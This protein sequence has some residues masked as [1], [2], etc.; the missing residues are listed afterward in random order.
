MEVTEN[1]LTKSLNRISAIAILPIIFL[2]G[3]VS[4]CQASNTLYSNESNLNNCLEGDGGTK[5]FINQVDGYCLLY[6]AEYEIGQPNEN[7]VVLFTGSLLNV[8]DPKVLI[9]RKDANGL[10]AAQ[11]ADVF[12][13]QFPGFDI[14]QT[15]D[16]Q[17]DGLE[18]VVLDNVPG[19]DLSR[20]L[21]IVS[22]D[23][24]YQFTFIPS[25]PSTEQV[26]REMKQVFRILSSSLRFIGDK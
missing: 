7:T 4:A 3:L 26:Y 22:G 9:E 11:L 21:F 25:D 18:A 16:L 17:F 5:S 23:T 24:A 20:V 10:S 2:V 13:N 12:S 14:T 19:Q 15:T 1:R 6:P 8:D